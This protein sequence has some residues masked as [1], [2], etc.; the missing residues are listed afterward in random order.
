[1]QSNH[2]SLPQETL[3]LPTTLQSLKDTPDPLLIINLNTTFTPVIRTGTLISIIAF[4]ECPSCYWH[5]PFN[6]HHQSKTEE[7]HVE[8]FYRSLWWWQSLY[9]SLS[10]SMQ[11][12]PRAP[13]II[14]LSLS[15]NNYLVN[16]SYCTICVLGCKHRLLADPWL[17]CHK[18]NNIQSPMQY[19]LPVPV[20]V[21]AVQIIF[22]SSMFFR[23][24]LRPCTS[25]WL[26]RLTITIRHDIK[27]WP[28]NL[29][30][31]VV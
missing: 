1:M 2:L 23:K 26:W 22:P 24:T 18:V 31:S 9:L 20:C 29:N 17:I 5:Q 6:H 25:N 16:N 3:T 15:V 7:L 14:K 11:H 27:T 8:S 30:F 21:L 13:P 28:R 12:M 4:V 19:M 10:L